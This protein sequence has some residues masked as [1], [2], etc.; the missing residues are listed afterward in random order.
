[1]CLVLTGTGVKPVHSGT[2]AHINLLIH[3]TMYDFQIRY[4]GEEK[5]K[6]AKLSMVQR[7]IA[8]CF[9]VRCWNQSTLRR[10]WLAHWF[11]LK[12]QSIIKRQHGKREI[13]VE[14]KTAFPKMGMYH[15]FADGSIRYASC[16]QHLTQFM[17]EKKLQR[18]DRQ[19]SKIYTYK[20]KFEPRVE[21]VVIIY[22]IFTTVH[23]TG[24][25]DFN[26]WVRA[27]TTL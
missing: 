12:L 4:G 24:M 19:L 10:T 7:N 15:L 16:L 22:I 2:C 8:S 13:S 3:V 18:R 1:M 14:V 17:R 21:N 5:H 25:V 11:T 23:L 9:Q 6:I 27:Q 26:F 20:N